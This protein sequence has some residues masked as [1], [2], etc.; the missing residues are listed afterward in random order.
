MTSDKRRFHWEHIHASLALGTMSERQDL[1]ISSRLDDTLR[2]SEARQ[3]AMR[4]AA[5]MLLVGGRG[6][7]RVGIWGAERQIVCIT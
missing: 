5:L 2:R 6:A 7:V 3:D 1:P 4:L